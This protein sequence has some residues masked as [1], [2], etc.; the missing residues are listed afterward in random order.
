MK[1]KPTG[2][3]LQTVLDSELAVTCQLVGCHQRCQRVC[4]S[5]LSHWEIKYGYVWHAALE[6]GKY[7]FDFIRGMFSFNRN[8]WLYLA[9]LMKERNAFQWDCVSYRYSDISINIMHYT[10]S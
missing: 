4:V 6:R 2:D 5:Q 10:S 3:N 8:V 7:V 9:Y 1:K